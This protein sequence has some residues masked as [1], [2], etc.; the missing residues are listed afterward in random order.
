[1]NQ[2]TPDLD[3]VA[4]IC[5]RAAH[6][7]L[8]ARINGLAADPTALGRLARSINHLLDVADS[9]VRESAAAMDHCS[10]GQFYRPILLRGL[11]GSYRD[12][13]LVINRA[14]LQ[15]K[16]SAERIAAF[17][18]ERARVAANIAQT[19]DAV[20]GSARHLDDTA[21]TI[22]KNA[23]QTQRLSSSV[24]SS[25]SETAS[26]VG[27]VA[28][29]CEQ[30]T[31]STSEISRQANDS[32][33]LTQ[34]AVTEADQASRAVRDLG[35]AARKIQSVV[36]LI[37]KIARQTNLLAL[38]ATIEA[39]RAGEHGRGFAIVANEV[40]VLSRNTS[41]ATDTIEE[42]VASMRQATENVIA[43]IDGIGASIRKINDNAG[44]I[45]TSVKEQVQATGEIAQRVTDVSTSTRHISNTI[46][47]VNTAASETEAAS[48][49]LK[50]A[51]AEL[52]R[53]SDSL[54]C[55]VGGL[56]AGQTADQ[57][58]LPAAA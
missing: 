47:E 35:E 11:P 51:S 25:A 43:A 57:E 55:E 26:S 16:E 31:S 32:A 52:S 13:A 36:G 41:E 24:A 42:Q 38:N 54:R 18:A 56:V 44:L 23:E 30:L 48:G 29:A 58:R 34:S 7:D 49:V 27:A 50:S 28:A 37:N 2:P 45:S 15:M 9:Y 6:G 8:E 46:G 3:Y 14:A 39:A 4:E 53:Q 17:Q 1:M 40:K 20:S 19:A 5:Q 33:E 22:W 21:Q 12:G 10:R